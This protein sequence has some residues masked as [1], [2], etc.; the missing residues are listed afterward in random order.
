MNRDPTYYAFTVYSSRFHINV[1]VFTAITSI[2]V[3]DEDGYVHKVI[4]QR[5]FSKEHFRG[6]LNDIN[7]GNKIFSYVN[8]SLDRTIKHAMQ[9]LSTPSFDKI[10][11]SDPL[12]SF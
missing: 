5:P 6:R 11:K 9:K 10:D 2:E 4:T 12:Y 3:D 8:P 7:P 1:P